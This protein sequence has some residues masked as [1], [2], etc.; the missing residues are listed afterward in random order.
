MYANVLLPVNIG[1]NTPELTYSVPENLLP[2]VLIGSAVRVAIRQKTYTGI[3][4]ELHERSISFAAK[5]ILATH[6]GGNL[7]EPWH[8]ELAQ[9]VAETT[10]T[11]FHKV[12]K[13]L[14]PQKLWQGAHAIPYDILFERTNQAVSGKLGTK[15]HELIKLFEQQKVWERS[16]LREFSRATLNSLIK[17]G[18]LIEKKGT[19]QGTESNSSTIYDQK[20]LTKDQQTIIKTIQASKQKKFLIHG[21]TGSGKTEI[22]LRLAQSTLEKGKQCILMVPEISLTPQLIGYFKELF[23]EKIAVL[24]SQLSTGE[25]EREWWR[26]QTGA[27]QIAIGSRSVIFAPIKNPGLIILDEEHEWSYKQDKAPFYHA[28]TVAFQISELTGAKVVLGSA[29]PDI[30]T[31]YAA[32]QGDIQKFTLTERLNSTS[33]LPPVELV[34]MR[35]ELK[36]KNFSIFSETLTQSLQKTL[37]SKE[38]AILFLNRRGHASSVLCRDC[39]NV[40]ECSQCDVSLTYHRFKNG[41]EQLVCHHCGL[42]QKL[43][44]TC[45]TCGS[46]SIK[47]MGLGTQRVEEELQKRFPTARILRADRDTTSKKHSFKDMYNTLKNGNADILIGTQMISKGLDLPNITLV[48]VMMAD[49]GLH[50]PDFRASE[51]A[52]QLLTQV[53]GRAGRDQKPGHV[54]IQTYNPDHI[55]LKTAAQH[56]YDTFY[57]QEII[58]RKRLNYPP[59]SRIVKLTFKHAEQKKCTTEIARI[60]ALLK[61][62]NSPDHEIQSAPALITRKHNKYRWHLFVQGPNPQILIQKIRPALQAG[63][64]ID[65]DPVV[66]N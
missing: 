44:E 53:A 8:I 30:E 25:R 47:F 3:I 64:S 62:I 18:L 50:I 54:V 49:I 19:I 42:T 48:G 59:F 61:K 65:V 11:P 17:K 40:C 57:K 58:S 56:D 51:R 26:L 45:N 63:W 1:K 22:Y 52:F 37:E 41:F 46:V 28:R 27:A 5:D 24:H 31:V 12:I 23:G 10:I 66:M 20:T 38:Q 4:T 34:D 33:S 16:D 29:T 39:G 13:M 14:L 35:E 2:H 55:S 32:E 60:E 15:Q 36:K 21:V 6:D 7:L 9:N 43:P